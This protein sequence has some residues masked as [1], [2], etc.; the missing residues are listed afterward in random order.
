EDYR[1]WEDN[2]ETIREVY[3]GLL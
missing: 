1:L 3:E 2:R